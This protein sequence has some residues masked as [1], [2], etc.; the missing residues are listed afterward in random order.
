MKKPKQPMKRAFLRGPELCLQPWLSYSPENSTNLPA[1]KKVTLKTLQPRPPE[2]AQL[3]LPRE[4]GA[5]PTHP[6]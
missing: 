2:L 1:M 3:T 6:T 4:R 5:A